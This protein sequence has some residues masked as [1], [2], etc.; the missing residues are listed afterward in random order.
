LSSRIYLIELSQLAPVAPTP[1]K[2]NPREA[3]MSELRRR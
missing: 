1:E 2:S 3:F